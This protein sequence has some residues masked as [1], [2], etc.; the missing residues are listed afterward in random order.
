V[1]L[2]AFLLLLPVLVDVVRRPTFRSLAVRSIGRRRGE[3]ALVIVGSLLGTAII[4]ASFVV[5]DTV[6][7]SIRDGARTTL[8]PVD[9]AVRAPSAGQLDE[10]Q[11]AITNPPI[12]GVD[13]TLKVQSA[14]V[15]V[16]NTAA[17]RRAEPV[18]AM[19][20][21]DFDQARAFGGDPTIT[22]LA[23]AGPTP[24]GDEVVIG[25]RL[26]T[27]LGV[28]VGDPVELF[29]YGGSKPFTVRQIVPG[30]GL[31]GYS[32]VR[33]SRFS[34]DR[35]VAVFVSPGT[36]ASMFATAPA[37]ASQ[38]QPPAT[39]VLVSN[40]G[41][42]FDG[43]DQSDAVTA[44][45]N[46]RTAAIAGT[47][48]GSL[49]ADL[50]AAAKAQ[51]DSLTQLFRS[52]GYFSVIAGILL[53]VNLFVMLSEERKT[54][55]GTL[56]AL[57]FKRNHL[58]R[59]FA[60][61]GATYSVVASI[62][63]AFVGIGVGWAVV[64]ATSS[65]FNR[66]NSNLD[67]SLAV[68][69]ASLVSGASLG[70]VIC[71]VTVWLT[72]A[73]IARLNIIRSIR[74]LPEP[75][76]SRTS[77]RP[78]FAGLAVA[79]VGTLAFV[80]GWQASTAALVLA[81]PAI[82]L[83][84]LIF[85][86][87]HWLPRKPVTVVLSFGALVWGIA[88]FSV[89]PEKVGNAGIDVFVVQG[90]VLV[91]AGVVILAQADR[92]WATLA[93]AVKA[94]GGGLSARLGLA[95]PLARKFRTALLL[96]MY[97]IVIFTMAFISVLSG[98]FANQ[99]PT[100]TAD[101]RAGFDLFVDSNP[102]NPV[103]T[104][105]LAARPGVA[106][107]AP[108]TRGLAQAKTARAPDGVPVPITGFDQSL[109]DQGQPK[110]D[111][112]GPGY[113]ADADVYRAVLGDPNLII[114][115]QGFGNRAQGGGP[116]QAEVLPGDTVTLQNAAT[117]AERTFT[118]AGVMGNDLTATGALVA[119]PVIDD[120]LGPLKVVNR[121]YV[122]VAPGADADEVAAGITGALI[123][124]GANAHT[125]RSVVDE[126]LQTQVGFFALLRAY[127]GLGLLIGIAG[128]GVV[129]VRAVR[130]RRREIG[131]LR[132]V[133]FSTVVVRRA[134]IF[135]AAFITLQGILLGIVL[136]MVT[137]YNL[138]TNSDAFGDQRLEITW[139]WTTLALIALVPLVASLVA[140]AWP[141]TQAARIRP[142]AALRIAD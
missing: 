17:D 100:F 26:A 4:T 3:A 117:R 141:A 68:K 39:V 53:L 16:A 139:P 67:L 60:I 108:F 54:E 121:H 6:E 32:P 95:Y 98:I 110:L 140:T 111:L 88:V 15:V 135:E 43:A 28:Q 80:A 72:S 58:V 119:N 113:G 84:G 122:K 103:T 134:F 96:G 49:K 51:G 90:I 123:P 101:V 8:G 24:R 33:A 45:L 35:P 38:A 70:L 132:A 52:I 50:L 105:Q 21:V 86:V 69:P 142:A 82:A 94:G 2:V 56:R 30:V 59:A 124:N 66:G 91:S 11:T 127:L 65:I 40:T 116:P 128:L 104:E 47:Q 92:V 22:G 31:A 93:R 87:G 75:R 12:A 118:V 125:F 114:V 7:A 41:G 18:G 81:G 25:E 23:D 44:E 130:E 97:S 107:V 137:S 42:I 83:F 63:G 57:G 120:L 76:L 138:L 109:L 131:M 112:R 78:V 13:G 46:R 34:G 61:E 10:V 79:A 64:K 36:V 74:D 102:G 27:N 85:V 133:G 5:G 55:L 14:G 77:L 29:A 1:R 73:R 71:L 9:E 89:A 37:G 20:E 99:A 19:V 136:G 48:V 129:M 115:N 106:A 126:V 62:L